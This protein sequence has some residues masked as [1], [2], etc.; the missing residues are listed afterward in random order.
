MQA[1]QSALRCVKRCSV[2]WP[3]SAPT[4]VPPPADALDPALAAE[5]GRV[6][7][8]DR[9]VGYQSMLRDLRPRLGGA[10]LFDVDMVKACPSMVVNIA[11]R[12]RYNG[13]LARVADFA[14]RD[15]GT[16]WLE[17]MTARYNCS[18]EAAKTLMQAALFG[19]DVARSFARW[20]REHGVA[21]SSELLPEVS[22]FHA[23]VLAFRAWAFAEFEYLF[24]HERRALRERHPGWSD[25]KLDRSLFAQWL[26]D[27]EDAVLQRLGHHLVSLGWAVVALIFDGLL[28][29]EAAREAPERLADDL[30]KVEAALANEGWQIALDVKPL[31]GTQDAPVPTIVEARAAMAAFAAA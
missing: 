26:F 13:D 1:V 20:K 10:R 5:H 3:Q 15:G 21:A 2:C 30:R 14:T 29:E 8:V 4:R 23:Q 7:L 6:L 16:R 18:K 9:A 11:R 24:A 25:A 28:V 31:H 22:E 17:T 19:D 12:R 27:A